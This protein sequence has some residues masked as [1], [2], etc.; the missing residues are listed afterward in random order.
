M[1]CLPPIATI[2]GLAEGPTAI[3]LTILGAAYFGTK[4]FTIISDMI[5]H[6]IFMHVLLRAEG[7]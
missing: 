2:E 1:N 5:L 6:C 7:V 3:R 4:Q